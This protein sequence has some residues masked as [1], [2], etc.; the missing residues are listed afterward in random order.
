[1]QE[2]NLEQLEGDVLSVVFTNPENGFTVLRLAVN[3]DSQK[4]KP[5]EKIMVGCL[6]LAVPGEHISAWGSW[7]VHPTRGERFEVSF[8]ERS[9]PMGTWGIH[10]YLSSG[11]VKGIGQAT[12]NLM[13]AKFG[14]NTLE[15][16]RNEP[17]KL[18]TIQ[19]ISLERARNLSR[20]FR[21]QT[22]QRVLM[23]Y[24]VSAGISPI[25]G[26]RLFRSFGEKSMDVLAE[27]PYVLCDDAIGAPFYQADQLALEQGLREDS[28]DRMAAAI[29]FEL[30]YNLQNGH[31]FLP[32]TKLLAATSELIG[33]ST[34]TLQE[35]LDA[36]LKQGAV[37]QEPVT[38]VSACYLES[39]YEAEE[40]VARRLVAMAGVRRSKPALNLDM[41]AANLEANQGFRLAEQ[42]RKTLDAAAV[43]QVFV[44]T[45][46]P[47]TGKTTTVRAVLA[48]CDA[49]HARTLLA[50]P[51]GQAA[52]RMAKLTGR[53]AA[54]IHRLLEA[55]V[56]PGE[57]M[58]FARNEERPLEC[59]VLILDECSMIDMQLMYCVLKALPPKSQLILV[60][61]RDQ[62]P[63]VGPGA[64]FRDI[65]RSN[66]LETVKLTQVFRQDRQ[67][68][69]VLSAHQINQGQ[70]PDLQVKKDGFFFLRR[71]DA[72][73]AAET[74]VSLCQDRL[75]RNMQIPSRQIQVLTPTRKGEA[76]TESLNSQLQQALNPAAPGKKEFPTSDRIFREGDR[77]MQIRNNYDIPWVTR[78]NTRGSGIFNGDIGYITSIDPVSRSFQVA[79]DNRT[80]TYAFDQTMELEHAWATTVHK[81]Q[82]SEYRAVIL[83][84]SQVPPKLVYRSLL[85]TAVTRAAELLIIVGDEEVIRQMIKNDYRAK[86]YTGLCQRMLRCR[87][88]MQN[89]R[90][91]LP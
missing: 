89:Q 66:I 52:K 23:D 45:G 53:N 71:K 20:L 55:G 26:L 4:D 29:R 3:Q 56:V 33:L 46:G 72:Q 74:V 16:L 6:P 48:L 61:D 28:T 78:N 39:L 73:S 14:E 77:V 64:V 44:L 12:A 32:D 80:A 90:P 76:G 84:L 49:L 9:L 86:R 22:D 70:V 42:Q 83:T 2:K 91:D 68:R 36:L 15:V 19:G 31:C 51:T 81:S 69:I 35:G 43:C 54:T 75:P 7:S 21:R 25:Y 50:A 17:E 27:N 47:G 34:Q 37:I 8:A 59:D 63:S 1:M 87:Q 65:I 88:E 60:G 10:K 41:L 30:I 67:S 82:G 62:L 57:G 79:F 40:Y 85:Y 5:E 13:V 58:V 18:A 38:N 11:A 24:L